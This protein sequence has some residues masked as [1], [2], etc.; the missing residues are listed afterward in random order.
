M[1]EGLDFSG[2]EK[3]RSEGTDDVLLD[4]SSD[5]VDPD[6]Q[7]KQSKKRRPPLNW[8]ILGSD[9]PFRQGPVFSDPDEPLGDDISGY[10]ATWTQ[11]PSFAQKA[12][13]LHWASQIP[14]EAEGVAP[15][16]EIP[17]LFLEAGPSP[18]KSLQWKCAMRRQLAG[19]HDFSEE[20][21]SAYLRIQRQKRGKAV[22]RQGSNDWLDLVDYVQVQIPRRR[23]TVTH[24]RGR[25]TPDEPSKRFRLAAL[26]ARTSTS[27]LQP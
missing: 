21:S 13:V 7:P 10:E 3:P 17:D 15:D 22:P 26:R 11:G 1:D 14:Q 9:S 2:E 24:L 12:Y 18:R 8:R 4:R 23:S 20:P 16:S 19:M 27:E 25:E 5:V 6:D